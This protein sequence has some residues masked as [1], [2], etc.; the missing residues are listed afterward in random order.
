MQTYPAPPQRVTLGKMQNPVRGFLHGFAAIASLAGGMLLWQHSPDEPGR[1]LALSVFAAS[2]FALY[3]VS[4]LYHSVPWQQRWKTRMQRIDHSMIYVLIA[5]TFTP[6]ACIVIDT[7][8]R[9]A[10]LGLTW[11]IA[12]VGAIQKTFFPALGTWFS[13]T[14]QTTQG[15]LGLLFFLPLVRKLPWQAP[16]LIVGGG[17]VYT[18]GMICFV[19]ERPRLWPRSF[20]YHEAFHVCVVMGSAAHYAM[21]F[22]YVAPFGT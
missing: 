11:G 21:I 18:I 2:L 7:P 5:G 15:W 13:V 8:L 4:S 17:L 19:T 10:A 9:Y 20:S 3:T 6:I 1:R 22:A 14:L 16:L 12:L